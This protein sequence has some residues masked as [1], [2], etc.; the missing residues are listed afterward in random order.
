MIVEKPCRVVAVVSGGP[1][2]TCYTALWLKRGCDVHALSFLYGQKAVVEVERAQ[3]LLRRLDGIAAE[4]GWG[5]V[6]EHRVVDL[7]SLGELWR[8]TQLT[9]PSVSVEQSY[10]PTVVVPIRNV[11][12]A[13]VATAYAYTVGRN[14]GAKTYVIL[15]S[16]YDDIKPRED[17]WEPLYPDCSPE[18]VEAMQTAFRI[19]HFRGER[20]VEIWTP[21]REGLRK[22]Q[23]LKM[24]HQEVGDLIYD[25]WSCY[26]SG[27]AHCGSCESC[28]NRHAAFTEAGLPDCTA[29]L[30]PPGP[31]FEKRGQFYLHISCKKQ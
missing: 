30:T 4:R 27:E 19:C 21:S 6:V 14:A 1:D 15:G 31:G 13:A 20:G 3:L 24:C 25:T 9:D 23:L 26:K 7:S 17:T 12:M 2:S 5:R 29:Y 16:H 8:G 18:C 11:V 10:T 28:K 22:S